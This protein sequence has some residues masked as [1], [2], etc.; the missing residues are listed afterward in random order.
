MARLAEGS[1]RRLKFKSAVSVFEG[2]TPPVSK[3]EKKGYP[4]K[5]FGEPAFVPAA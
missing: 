1:R 5:K 2:V 4:T 3:K